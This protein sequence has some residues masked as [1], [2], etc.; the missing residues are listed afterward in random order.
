MDPALRILGT[1]NV[2]GAITPTG[3]WTSGSGRSSMSIFF[4]LSLLISSLWARALRWGD[5]QDARRGDPL[6]RAGGLAHQCCK[7]VRP[8]VVVAL[9]GSPFPGSHPVA[10]GRGTP[11]RPRRPTA[12]VHEEVSVRVPGR[13]GLTQLEV[14]AFAGSPGSGC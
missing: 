14:L 4:V 6:A 13:C 11:W 7:V 10:M 3:A 12:P 2:I 8:M 9:S 5:I 1:R